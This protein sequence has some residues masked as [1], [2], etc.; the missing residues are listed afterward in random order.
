MRM[1]VALDLSLT[2]TGF[3]CT[4]GRSGVLN[5]PK[6]FDRG[7]PR[8]QWIMNQVWKITEGADLVVIEGY[9]FDRP[10][11]AHQI[12]E[13]GG[14]IRFTLWEAEVPRPY[15]EIAP[16]SMKKFATGKGNASKPEVLV[17]AVRKLGYRG[18]STDEADALWLLEMARAHYEKRT[19]TVKQVEALDK[20]DWPVLKTSLQK[21]EPAI[22]HSST[23]LDGAKEE[24]PELAF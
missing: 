22:S 10:N 2:A 8:L 16:S 24:M 12:G 7:M 15:I 1:I 9:A 23:S 4:D 14:I 13:L 11:Q 21:A 18:A 17:E 20:I 19:L 6:G 3:A 5:P